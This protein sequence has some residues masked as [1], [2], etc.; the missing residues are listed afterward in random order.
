[1]LDRRAAPGLLVR[2]RGGRL[3][4]GGEY[5]RGEQLRAAGVFAAAASL[6]CAAAVRSRQAKRSLPRPVRARVRPSN[7]RAGWYIDRRAF[8]TDLYR[9]GRAARLRSR[10]GGSLL[11]QDHLSEAWQRA[12]PVVDALLD[13]AE[14][15][16]V[17]RVVDGELPIPLEA[18][19][20]A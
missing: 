6:T 2:P 20:G 19:V 12:R 17:D 14:L 18:V 15:G 13:A 11:A 4:L 8:G 5:C 7:I 3:E 16:L 1:V 10:A 9:D